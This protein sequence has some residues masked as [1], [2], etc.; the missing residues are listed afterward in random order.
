MAYTELQKRQHIRELQMFLHGISHTAPLPHLIPDGIYGVQTA[1]VVRQFQQQNHLPETGKADT[2][3]WNALAQAYLQDVRPPTM[4][5]TLFPT[6][7]SAYAPGDSG[8]AVFLIQ[9]ILQ[10]LR[11]A[12][13]EISPVASSGTY[14]A[15][16]QHAVRQFQDYTPLPSDGIVDAATWNHLL[17]ALGEEIHSTAHVRRT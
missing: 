12:F 7:V 2:E 9:G 10:A 1:E 8:S 5:L 14:D 17:A 13:P 16:T 6:G 3:T 11:A 4:H 15:A